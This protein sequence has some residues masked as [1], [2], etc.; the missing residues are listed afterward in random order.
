MRIDCSIRPKGATPARAGPRPGARRLPQRFQRP[1]RRT[2]SGS[3]RGGVGERRAGDRR[4]PMLTN[5]PLGEGHRIERGVRANEVVEG[6]VRRGD[7]TRHVGRGQRLENQS[8]RRVE[9]G[10]VRRGVGATHLQ[11]GQGCVL[12]DGR[13]TDQQRVLHLVDGFVERFRDHHVA[14]A[15]A[16]H[17][18]RLGQ[19]VQRDRVPARVVERPR[20]ER[21]DRSVGEVLVGLVVQVEEAARLAQAVDRGQRV[22]GIDRPGGIVRRYGNDPA[23]PR[24]DGLLDRREIELIVAVRLDC[25]RLGAGHHDRHLVIEVVRRRQD[26]LVARI[27]DREH[28]VHERL[29]AASGHQQPALRPHLDPVLGGQLGL[30]RRH[31]RGQPFDRAV[32]MIVERRPEAL[33]GRHR[34]RRRA[35]R[36]HPLTE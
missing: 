22:R 26:D 9:A 8:A 19:R 24:R 3:S 10:Q 2:R 30:E 29:I 33:R 28:R 20:R 34:L 16:G 1:A 23:G 31:Q 25:D 7:V 21:R 32:A 18:V 15:P 27:G 36:N 35:I 11:R 12:R 6:T 17:P 14:D 4:D 5:Q 13:R